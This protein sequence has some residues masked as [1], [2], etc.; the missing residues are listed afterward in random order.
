[1]YG[2]TDSIMYTLDNDPHTHNT[3]TLTIVDSVPGSSG[4]TDH[5]VR[6]K[7]V[8]NYLS[9][10]SVRNRYTRRCIHAHH[11]R[12]PGLVPKIINYIMSYTILGNLHIEQQCTNTRLLDGSLCGVYDKMVLITPKVYIARCGT[13]DI[14][15]VLTI[16][17]MMQL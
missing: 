16:V 4:A 8:M 2:D 13:N 1:M 14:W 3:A 7:A 11:N 17:V 10:K 12:L 15:Q 9:G 6:D 5:T